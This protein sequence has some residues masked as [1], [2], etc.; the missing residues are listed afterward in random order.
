VAAGLDQPFGNSSVLPAYICAQQAR[1]DGVTRMLAGDGGDEL[2]GGNTRYAKQRVFDWY[3]AVPGAM[4]SVVLEPVF[5]L[6]FV[7]KTPLL[8]KGASYIEQA[9]VPMP[10]R[11]QMYNL[12]QRLGPPNV[13]TPGFLAQV[14][15][16]DPARQQRDVWDAAKAESL[17]NR[18]LAYDWRYTLAEIDLPKVRSATQLAGVDVD[19]PLLDDD[20]LAFSMRLSSGYKLKGLKLRWFFKEA[21]RGF[22]PDEIIAKKKHGFGLPFGVWANKHAGLRKLAIDSLESFRGRG[23]VRADF[24]DELVKTHLPAHPGYYGEMVWILMMLEQWI[25]H[26]NPRFKA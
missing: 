21:L 16:G 12:L 8:G 13:L 4:R 24:I 3:G 23:I 5:G 22:L 2:F 26:H 20:L 7:A 6:P 11:M 17:V 1:Q 14:D 9:R 18:T 15:P 25:Q 10:E 19:F